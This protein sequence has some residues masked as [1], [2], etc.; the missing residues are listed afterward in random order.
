MHLDELAKTL[1]GRREVLNITQKDLAELSEVGLRTL[2]AI[3]RGKTNPTFDTLHKIL[4]VLGLEL[5]IT[6]RKPKLK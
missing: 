6:V 4:E 5:S 3:E 1:K 2:K